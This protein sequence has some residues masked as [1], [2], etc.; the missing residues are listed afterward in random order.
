MACNEILQLPLPRLSG[1]MGLMEALQNR[2]TQREFATTALPMQVLADL[3]WATCGVNRPAIGGR[4]VPKAIHLQEIDVYVALPSGLY[5]YEPVEHALR[6]RVA[7]DI[8]AVTGNQDFSAA[9]ALDLVIVADNSRLHW[10]QAEQRHAYACITAGAMVQNVYL[11]SA[12]MG[13]A[14]VV[15][16]WIDQDK[17]HAA[18]ALDADQR[19]LLALSVGDPAIV[20]KSEVTEPPRCGSPS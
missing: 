20:A 8:R 3:L 17:L 6:L 5:L 15:R 4:T 18:M 13:L 1:G 10:V 14:T 19:A 16:A 9:A 11:I 7:R 2:Q 12:A